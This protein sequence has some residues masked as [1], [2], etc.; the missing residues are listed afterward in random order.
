MKTYY[1]LESDLALGVVTIEVFNEKGES[2]GF[3]SKF[4]GLFPIEYDS[5]AEA[6]A[7]AR[8]DGL[9]ELPQELYRKL[10]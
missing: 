1:L 3:K 10:D 8:Q 2:C 7:A 5:L 9:T 6:R 4:L